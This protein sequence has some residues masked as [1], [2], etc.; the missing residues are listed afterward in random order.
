MIQVLKEGDLKSPI[1]RFECLRCNCV[2]EAD[3]D[4]YKLILTSGD[5]AYITDCPYCHKRVARMI[6]KDR[7]YI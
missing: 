6:I 7:R 2:F 5:L 4:D 3:K 1:I